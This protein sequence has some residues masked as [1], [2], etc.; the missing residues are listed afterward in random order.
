[1]FVETKREGEAPSETRSLADQS[2]EALLRAAEIIEQKGRVTGCLG[3]EKIG[4]CMIGAIAMALTGKSNGNVG[5]AGIGAFARLEKVVGTCNIGM[6]N[7]KHST[8]E[9][10]TALRQ[11]ANGG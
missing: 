5:P 1:M 2:R 9:A 7:D 3:N 8:P 11:A 10:L 6:W 4:F